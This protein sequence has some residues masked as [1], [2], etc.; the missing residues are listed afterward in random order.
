MEC[1]ICSEK[2]IDPRTTFTKHLRDKHKI[3]Y[4]GICKQFYL[5][6]YTW[7]KYASYLHQKFYHGYGES[8][9]AE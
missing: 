4:C 1:N 5:S 7:R 6:N 8:N 2:I 3:H 9:Y